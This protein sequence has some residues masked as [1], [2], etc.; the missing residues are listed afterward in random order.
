MRYFVHCDISF[1]ISIIKKKLSCLDKKLSEDEQE[2]IEYFDSVT[3]AYGFTYGKLQKSLNNLNIV[4]YRR[5]F[6]EVPTVLNFCNAVILFYNFIEYNN[7]MYSIIDTCIKHNIPLYIFSQHI[8]GCLYVKNTE[9]NIIKNFSSH[10]SQLPKIYYKFN[11]MNIYDY[12]FYKKP[13]L[14]SYKGCVDLIKESYQEIESI[15]N[16]KRAVLI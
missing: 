10:I 12:E 5:S 3:I 9:W 7:G 15:K 14:L 11:D 4:I 16:D 6:S 8:S 1:P 2:S 13:T